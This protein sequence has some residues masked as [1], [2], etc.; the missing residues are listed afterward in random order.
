MN[1]IREIYR[2]VL[3]E[4]DYLKDVTQKMEQD[5]EMFLKTD[6]LTEQHAYEEHRDNLFGLTMRMGEEYFVK[7]FQYAVELIWECSPKGDDI[8]AGFL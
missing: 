3:Q 5:I 7:G 4:N 1:K 8:I 2:T 6:N